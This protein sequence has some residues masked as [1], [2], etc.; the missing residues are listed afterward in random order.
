MAGVAGGAAVIVGEAAVLRAAQAKEERGP[1]RG[2]AQKVAASVVAPTAAGVMVA[3]VMAV[4]AAVG[5]V[6][7]GV[8][9]LVGAKL[10]AGQWGWKTAAG[11]L[12]EMTVPKQV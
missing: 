3:G 11:I 5:V 2:T 4:A 1:A 7:V 10:A 8:V 6:L 9:R 12:E